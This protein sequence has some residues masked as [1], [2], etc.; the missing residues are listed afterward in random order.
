MERRRAIRRSVSMNEPLGHARLRTGGQLRVV[1]ASSW[2]A[3]VETTDRLLPNR[4]LDVH[5]MSAEGRLLVR[6]RVARAFVVTVE[7]DAVRYHAA[8]S[9]E[10]AIDIRTEGY[11][12]PSPLLEGEGAR[13][14]TYPARPSSR[15]IEFAESQSSEESAAPPIVASHLV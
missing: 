7:A 11:V 10:R 1:E 12:L 15:D 3:L 14:M 5:F 9:F 8:L 6:C 2:G 13:G 4:H